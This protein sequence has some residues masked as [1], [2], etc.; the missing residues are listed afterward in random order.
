MQQFSNSL[1]YTIWRGHYEVA[2]TPPTVG[3]PPGDQ[4]IKRAL[5]CFLMASQL[6]REA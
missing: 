5:A 4:V 2:I 6:A 1:P 3:S